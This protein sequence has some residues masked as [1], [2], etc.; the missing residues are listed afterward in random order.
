M[1]VEHNT[2]NN[3]QYEFWLKQLKRAIIK[4]FFHF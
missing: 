2:Y 3:L 4:S 1:E